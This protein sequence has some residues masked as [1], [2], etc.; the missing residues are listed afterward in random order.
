MF[1]SLTA[2]CERRFYRRVCLFSIL[3]FWPDVNIQFDCH[4]FEIRGKLTDASHTE[5]T[6]KNQLTNKDQLSLSATK[7]HFRRL[8]VPCDFKF[9][10][11]IG[12]AYFAPQFQLLTCFASIVAP[13]QFVN[14]RKNSRAVWLHLSFQQKRLDITSIF[15]F[16]AQRISFISASNLAHSCFQCFAKKKII[17]PNNSTKWK[18]SRKSKKLAK[19]CLTRVE[20][21][22]VLFV[23]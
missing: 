7:F 4:R 16:G 21:L 5:R 12:H 11:I 22:S 6:F 2:Q 19:V 13:A 14:E 17:K 8:L 1:P 20:Q 23:S 9:L 10:A 15:Q 3:P 18:I